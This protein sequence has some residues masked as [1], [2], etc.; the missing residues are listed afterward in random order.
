MHFC[1]PDMTF[2]FI[3]VEIESWLFFFFTLFLGHEKT[4]NIQL[5]TH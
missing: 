4:Q 2:T 5:D 1:K 3:I